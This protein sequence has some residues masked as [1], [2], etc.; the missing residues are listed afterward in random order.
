MN[1]E[2][3]Y[4]P[5]RGRLNLDQHFRRYAWAA[6]GGA[7]ITTIGGAIAGAVNKP[8]AGATAAFTPVN[9]QDEQNKALQGN[10]ANQGAINSLVNSTNQFDQNQAL[11]LSEQAAPG[12]TAL[13][14]K[15][16]DTSSSLLDNPYGVPKDV[17]D[18]ISRLAAERGISA[19]TRGQFSDFSLLRDLGVNSL[20]YGQSRINQ[21]GS[22][23]GLVNSIAPKVNPM[24]PL[25]FYVTPAQSAQVAAGNNAGQQ[26]TQQAANNA[27]AGAQNYQN[28]TWANLINGASAFGAGALGKY[29]GS[30]NGATGGVGGGASTPGLGGMTPNADDSGYTMDP[31]TVYK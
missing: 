13:R 31:F 22:L 24:S 1:Y 27:Q 17:Q 21:A 15:L 8:K 4:I 7:A 19:G 10:L 9:L 26:N 11:S 3:E 5:I 23:A 16:T 12:I 18:N 28:A 25:S 29:L 2:N 6:I 14:K 30:G 20:Q